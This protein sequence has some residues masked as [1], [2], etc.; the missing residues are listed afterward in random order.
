M[1]KNNNSKVVSAI[2]LGL[3]GVVIAPMA[4]AELYV[5]PVLRNTVKMD[6]QE[7]AI[8]ADAPQQVEQ[9]EAATQ[10]VVVQQLSGESS[11]HGRFVMK[12]KSESKVN[13]F[14]Y[15]KNVPLFIAFD[16][17]VPQDER[18]FVHIDDGL[19]NS[20]VNW[21]GGDS[22]ESVLKTIGEQNGLHVIV[23][24]EERAIGVSKSE[25]IAFNLAKEIPQVWRLEKGLSLRKN[26]DKWAQKAGWS[27]EWDK[28]LDVDYVIEH[29]AVLTGQFVGSD[30]VVAK[31]LASMED[32][33]VPLKARFY[34]N[35]NVLLIKQA[36]F[37][38]QVRY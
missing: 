18:W 22:W 15:G 10:P 21:E 37:D 7:T 14:A 1:N 3:A 35:N 12:E 6:A 25:K 34:K 23:N 24:T 19:E 16:K 33:E 9:G 8:K 38:Q 30:G 2:V 31:I 17:I 29:G 26:I 4:S 20:V 32:R 27:L 13:P 28:D 36:G 11:V 5:S